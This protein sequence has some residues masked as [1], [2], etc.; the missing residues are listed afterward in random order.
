[1]YSLIFHDGIHE[2]ARADYEDYA[3]AYG[4]LLAILDQWCV[5]RAVLRLGNY[6]RWGVGGTAGRIGLYTYRLRDQWATETAGCLELRDLSESDSRC[7]LAPI[8]SDAAAACAAS[9][10]RSRPVSRGRALDAAAAVRTAEGLV[11]S[12][13]TTTRIVPAE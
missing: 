4:A 7:T 3:D 10:P 8:R 1:M 11:N 6:V 2:L 5:G 9:V 13:R 12:S